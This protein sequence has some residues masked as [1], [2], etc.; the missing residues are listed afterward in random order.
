M[1]DLLDLAWRDISDCFGLGHDSGGGLGQGVD[2]SR[3]PTD[4][5]IRILQR[6]HLVERVTEDILARKCIL[7]LIKFDFV[8]PD[9][10]PHS[11]TPGL[12]AA[13]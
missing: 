9:L 6:E 12:A 8:F 3:L 7:R 4:D 10:L 2:E 5:T 1:T 11:S 13:R